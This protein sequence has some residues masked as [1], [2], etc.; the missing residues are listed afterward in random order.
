[1]SVPESCAV[2]REAQLEALTAVSIGLPLSC[3][4]SLFSSAD[5]FY[6]AAG[7]RRE[8]AIASVRTLGVVARTRHAESSILCPCSF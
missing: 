2:R 3:E 6:S 7:N 5:L 1:M 4:G 8:R